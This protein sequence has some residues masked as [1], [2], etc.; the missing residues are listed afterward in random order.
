LQ[1]QNVKGFGA[2]KTS[3]VEAESEEHNRSDAEFLGESFLQGHSTISAGA[4]TPLGRLYDVAIG[5][6]DLKF[7]YRAAGGEFITVDVAYQSLDARVGD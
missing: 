4:Q 6:K 1:R 7:T 2:P 5:A 3:T